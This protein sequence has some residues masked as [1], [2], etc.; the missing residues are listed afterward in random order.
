[1]NLFRLSFTSLI[2]IWPFLFFLFLTI[3]FFWRFFFKGLIPLPADL[4][5]GAYYPWLDYKWGFPAGVPVKNPILSD[6]VSQLYLWSMLSVDII[7]TGHWPL[8]NPF[9]FAGTPLLATF[10]SATLYPLNALLFLNQKIGWGLLIASQPLLAMTFMY[11]YLRTISISKLGSIFG[12][13]IFSF[14]GLMTTRLEFGTAVHTASWLPLILLSTEKFLSRMKFRWLLLSTFAWLFLILAGYS[15]IAFYSI[16]IFVIYCVFRIFTRK[17]S[18]KQRLSIFIFVVFPLIFGLLLSSIQ[19][20]P[21]F[22]LFTQSIR[23]TDPYIKG[24]NFGL[25]PLQ[26]II[27]FFAP[28]FFGHHS[29]GNFWGF[30]NYPETAGFAG[31][32]AVILSILAATR[33]RNFHSIFFTSLLIISLLFVFQTP[34]GKM[35]YVLHLPVIGVASASRALFIIGFCLSILG[36]FGLDQLERELKK[37]RKLIVYVLAGYWVV[38]AAIVI[39]ILISLKLFQPWAHLLDIELFSQNL[40]VGLRNLVFPSGI[41]LFATISIIFLSKISIRFTQILLIMIIIVDLF[42]FSWK[43]NPFV[44]KHLIFPETPLIEFLQKQQFPFRI[45]AEPGEI[46]PA[47]MWIAYGI[48]SI[49]GYDPLYSKRFGQF[50]Q[51]INSGGFSEGVSR[52]GKVENFSSPLFDLTN[53]KYVLLMKRREDSTPGPDGTK[54]LYKYENLNK[55]KLIFEDGTVRVYEN[56]KAFNRAYLVHNY[57]VEREENNLAKRLLNEDLTKTVLLE[58]DPLVVSSKPYPDDKV[59]LVSYS[60][61]SSKWQVKT[62]EPGLLVVADSYYPGW[63]VLVDGW[64]TRIY[65]ANFAFRAVPVP[66]GEHQVEFIYDPLSFKIGWIVSLGALV[67]LIITTTALFKRKNWL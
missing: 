55:L 21:S 38:V 4:V 14:A 66:A 59:N 33:I 25:L 58:E 26:N 24:V 30:W 15:Q 67:V 61:N 32:L 8:W 63:R 29:T 18:Y 7:K 41:L 3:I 60:A 37:K 48:E 1:M 6:V 13:I 28:D 16:L 57:L 20:L 10:H 56:T 12:A 40:R 45:V 44:S 54:I 34:F 47:N 62:K 23:S 51:I 19:I 50:L 17:E 53:T 31:V 11:L 43:Y 27:T 64:D 52:Y 2:R 49:D 22:E 65:R 39:G 5:V 9:S 46:F 42:R 36:A 35:P